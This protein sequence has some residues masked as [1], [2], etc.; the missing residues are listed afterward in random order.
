MKT[1][2][3][4]DGR[5]RISGCFFFLMIACVI[6]L[7][8]CA[9]TTTVTPPKEEQSRSL[10]FGLEG[11]TYIMNLKVYSD[12]DKDLFIY[13]TYAFDYTN[14]ENPLLEK[15]LFKILGP[16]FT[17][18]GLKKTKDNPDILV[19]MNFYTGKKEKYTPPQTITTTQIKQVWE[20]GMIG[21]TMTGR[22]VPV[23]ITESQTIP[24]RTEI[25]Y[26]SNIRLNFF[27]Y[28]TLSSGKKLEIPPVVWVGEVDSEGY[29][30][31][32]RVVAPVMLEELI[33]NFPRRT[34]TG[35]ETK[36]S[37]TIYKYG[38]TG[39]K[40]YGRKSRVSYTKDKEVVIQYG[41]FIITGIEPGS[42][43]ETAGL[44]E[45]DT[46][47]KINGNEVFIS[48]WVIDGNLLYNAR[49]FLRQYPRT[50]EIEIEVRSPRSKTTQK[51]RL[52]P[53]EVTRTRR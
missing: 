20:S 11:A 44:H 22:Y 49:P 37:C 8:G 46:I 13:K 4:S 9:T 42:Q 10:V 29:S 33:E 18:K 25:S 51:I 15:E 43:A 34:G 21:W 7:C 28:P 50:G 40:G 41:A 32:I 38:T 45:G 26:Y 19:I 47:L 48:K 16:I 53:K 35:T 31:D 2:Y 36:K 23:P 3:L 1:Y 6:G 17:N 52:T 12:P 30:S 27:D 39:I 14:K 5:R 24:E